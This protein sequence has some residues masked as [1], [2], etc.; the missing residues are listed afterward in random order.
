MTENGVEVCPICGGLGAVVKDV[1]VGD[2][3]F[4]KAFP[5]ICQAD[6]IKARHSAH[7]RKLGNL[8]A[9]QNMTFATFQIDHS[10]IDTETAKPLL[11]ICPTLS[12]M[13][14]LSENQ[15]RDINAVAEVAF[16][17]A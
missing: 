4:G 9:Y 16:Y 7:L 12:R 6:K 8:D 3:D 17:Y 14:G 2:P 1:E 13:E 10:L 5:C 15:R 11:D